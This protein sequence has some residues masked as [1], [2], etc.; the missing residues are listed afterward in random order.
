M[1]SRVSEEFIIS[2]GLW[3]GHVLVLQGMSTG[4][5]KLYMNIVYKEWKK[6]CE[7]MGV[8][9]TSNIYLLNL[10]FADDQIIILQ[11]YCYEFVNI[12]TKI[13]MYCLFFNYNI[14]DAREIFIFNEKLCD[15][16]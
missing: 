11:E 5:L 15:F 6:K 12:V 10:L 4:L 13:C 9:L 7:K 1:G 2:K 8:K 3:Q 16:S 14:S